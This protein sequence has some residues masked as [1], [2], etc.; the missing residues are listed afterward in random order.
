MR[1]F[2]YDVIKSLI[3]KDDE[4]TLKRLKNIKKIQARKKKSDD[5]NNEDNSDGDENDEFRIKSKP[6]V[7]S[8]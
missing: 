3:P 8:L 6:K 7:G 1:K 4:T 5:Q 2:D